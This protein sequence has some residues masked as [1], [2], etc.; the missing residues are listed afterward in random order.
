MK[1]VLQDRFAEIIRS[2]A[3]SAYPHECC[4]LLA[5][6]I[7]ADTATISDVHPSDN[8]TRG[9]PKRGFEVDPK[10]RFDVMRALEAQDDGTE[11]IGHYH[12]HPDHPAAPSKTDLA[13]VY[14]PHFI[15]I[16]CASTSDGAQDIGAFRANK[17]VN[18]FDRLEIVSA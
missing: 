5:G 4:G 6:R 13:M 7:E 3:A 2:H 12:S 18:D 16:I 14:E 8:V 11:I 9:D 17:D 1:V 10:L 15:W